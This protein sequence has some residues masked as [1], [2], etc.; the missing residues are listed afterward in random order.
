MNKIIEILKNNQSGQVLILALALMGLGGLMIAPMLS[1]MGTGLEA[2][3]TAEEKL[4]EIYACD[5]GVQDAIWILNNFNEPGS[6]SWEYLDL[7]GDTYNYSDPVIGRNLPN[8]NGMDVNVYIENIDL[9][10][11]WPV[12]RVRSWVGGTIVDNSTIIDAFI[13]TKWFDYTGITEHVVT[14]Q[15]LYEI[16]DKVDVDPPDPYPTDP[17]GARDNYNGPW[18]HPEDLIAWYSR[19]IEDITPYAGEYGSMPNPEDT[20]EIQKVPPIPPPDIPIR[21]LD[22]LYHEGNLEI[23]N[24]GSKDLELRL[25]GTVYVTET[26]L[27]GTTNQ[28]M[29]LDLNGNTIF[30]VSDSVGSQPALEVGG[31]CTLTGSGCLIA[32]GDIKFQPKMDAS[33]NDYILVLSI[34]GTTTMFPSGTFYG[35]LAGSVHVDVKSGENPQLYWNG[36][37]PDLNFPGYTGGAGMVWGVHSWSYWTTG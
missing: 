33:P 8:V 32:V 22:T 9:M 37:P 29:R 28:D 10:D 26:L 15:S 19:D 5:A 7:I 34:I 16:D 3:V 12:Y 18:P 27:I 25:H 35:T 11:G 17:N 24:K 2:G 4:D 20:I 1:L 13:T 6:I 30:V 21:D 14:S 23:V 36:P 31:K